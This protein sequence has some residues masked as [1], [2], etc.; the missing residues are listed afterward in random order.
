L[1]DGCFS[2]RG[3][4]DSI[5]FGPNSQLSR[6]ESGTRLNAWLDPARFPLPSS[7]SRNVRSRL[8]RRF[9][10]VR[11]SADLLVHRPG[12]SFRDPAKFWVSHVAR[13][14]HALDPSHLKLALAC[15]EL[16]PRHFAGRMARLLSVPSN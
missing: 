3:S 1:R 2:N 14:A 12:L 16:K 15:L 10:L 7:L 8:P 13:A 5:S 9:A 4:L 11:A 6:I